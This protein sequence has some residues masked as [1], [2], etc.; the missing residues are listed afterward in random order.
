MSRGEPAPARITNGY[1]GSSTDTF[2]CA[3]MPSTSVRIVLGASRRN[4]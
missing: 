4:G 2:S 1:T 3:Q